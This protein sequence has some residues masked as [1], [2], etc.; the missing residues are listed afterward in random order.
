[1]RLPWPSRLKRPSSS[2]RTKS[3]AAGS[4]MGR[5]FGMRL[6]GTTRREMRGQVVGEIVDHA[7]ERHGYRATESADGGELD[8]AAHVA[9]ERHELILPAVRVD[10]AVQEMRAERGHLLR[11]EAARDAF[12]A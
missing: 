9:H 5:G 4:G 6:S 1:M 11:A 3:P 12:A 10:L 2:S 8:G 7:T